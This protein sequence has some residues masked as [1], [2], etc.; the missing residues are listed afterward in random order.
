MQ[1]D[2]IRTRLILLIVANK[3]SQNHSMAEFGRDLQIHLAQTLLQQGLPGYLTPHAG[4]F[5]RTPR[6]RPHSS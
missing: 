6:R 4:G 1:K 3:T 2:I 5:W